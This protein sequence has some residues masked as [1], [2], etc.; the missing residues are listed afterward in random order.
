MKLISLTYSRHS[1]LRF[2]V[3]A[4]V[5]RSRMWAMSSGILILSIVG[6]V[7][8]GVILSVRKVLKD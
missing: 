8:M 3:F 7:F 5:M 6:L 2:L 4:L 1:L